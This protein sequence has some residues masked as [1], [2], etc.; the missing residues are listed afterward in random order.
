MQQWDFVMIPNVDITQMALHDFKTTTASVIISQH[1][2]SCPVQPA[3]S[4]RLPKEWQ[5]RSE[6][7]IALITVTI[8]SL[9]LYKQSQA[10]NMVHL[11]SHVTAK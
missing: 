3:L 2:P 10:L 5:R 6:G 7:K 1:Y 11:C 8:H 4:C 9:P